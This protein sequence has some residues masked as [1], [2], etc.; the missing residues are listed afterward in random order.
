MKNRSED[1]VG[2]W[3]FYAQR[4]VAYAFAETLKAC[5]LQHKKPYVITP[6]QWGVLSLLDEADGQTASAI[7]QKRGIDA[8]TLTG[9]VTRLEQA[10]L[11]ERRHYREDRRIVKVYLTGEGRDFMPFLKEAAFALDAIATQ[12]FSEAEQCDLIARLQQIVANLSAIGL[13]D[14][15]GLLPSQYWYDRKASHA[16]NSTVETDIGIEKEGAL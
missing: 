8:P 15:F 10:G 2:Y 5:C 1:A 14:R 7:S 12:G 13:G 6:S 4:C 3:L 9:I 11:V 16:S